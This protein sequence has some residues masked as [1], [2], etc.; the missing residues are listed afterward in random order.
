MRYTILD[1]KKIKNT[2][3]ELVEYGDK[4]YS[5]TKCVKGITTHLFLNKN[6]AEEYEFYRKT[7][8]Y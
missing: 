7:V 2:M 8:G 6:H 1:S 3:Y 4:M 5:V